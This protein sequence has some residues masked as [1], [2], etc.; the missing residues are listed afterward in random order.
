MNLANKEINNQKLQ[1]AVDLLQNNTVKTTPPFTFISI[2]T[3][4]QW[5]CWI[6]KTIKL[7]MKEHTIWPMPLEITQW[8]RY[9]TRYL[10]LLSN[11]YVDTPYTWSSKERHRR[12]R[13]SISCICIRK[14]CS[15]IILIFWYLTSIFVDFHRHSPLSILEEM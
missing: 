1:S 12:R 6:S 4:R 2:I 15:K 11:N 3:Y 10:T 9:F 5:L 14:Q 8:D 7:A 13:C